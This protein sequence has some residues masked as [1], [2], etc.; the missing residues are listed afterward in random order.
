MDRIALASLIALG[1]AVASCQP[2][3]QRSIDS[4]ELAHVTLGA[5]GAGAAAVEIAAH[6]P[7]TNNATNLS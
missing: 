7:Q 4:A 3:Q 6:I 1:I 5:P 2:F